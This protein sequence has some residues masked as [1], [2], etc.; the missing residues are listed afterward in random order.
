MR[1][2][3]CQAALLP[4]GALQNNSFIWS[5]RKC[6]PC[7]AALLLWP[8]GR[9]HFFVFA[10]HIP[11]VSQTVCGLFADTL[12]GPLTFFCL[13]V[14]YKKKILQNIKIYRTII[15]LFALCGCETWSLTLRE[16]RRLR[17]FENGVLNRIFGPER[18]EQYILRSLT[19]WS[20]N[21]TF[22]FQHTLQVKCK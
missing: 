5:N 22:K 18:E 12:P 9:E 20:R 6:P 19:F 8:F 14:C 4:E 10:L 2:A 1:C 11:G 16:E 15:L 3:V 17:V 21:F 13:P 7:G